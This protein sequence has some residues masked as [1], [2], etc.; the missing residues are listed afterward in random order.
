MV[1]MSQ[2]GNICKIINELPGL[3]I[4][5]EIQPTDLVSTQEFS[6]L[7]QFQKPKRTQGFLLED[8]LKEL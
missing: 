2:L 8:S 4:H 6:M 7:G 3:L 1:C 5:D